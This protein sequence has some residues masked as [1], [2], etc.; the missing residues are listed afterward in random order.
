MIVC[1][2]RDLISGSEYLS[3]MMLSWYLKCA[4]III[5]YLKVH[6][7][8]FYLYIVGLLKLIIHLVFSTLITTSQNL[9]LYTGVCIGNTRRA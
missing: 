9:H 5:V 1:P 7:T 2:I 6:S 8:C 4:T 3:E